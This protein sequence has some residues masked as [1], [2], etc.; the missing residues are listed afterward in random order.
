MAD[1]HPSPSDAALVKRMREGD[2]RA[3]G[4]LYD[5]H[6]GSVY[7]LARSL[8]AEAADADEVVT[9]AFLSLWRGGYDE[10]RGSV[11]AFLNVVAR[12]RALD[13]IRSRRRRG[14]AEERSAEGEP[15]GFAVP[16]SRPGGPEDATE[17]SDRRRVI[18]EALGTLSEKQRS[19]I[20]LAYL[21]GM[22]H[23]EIAAHLSEP[24]GTV[25]TR[26][27]DGMKKL[28][29]RYARTPGEA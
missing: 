6:A 4:L 23:R 18:R 5:R 28:R 8:V 27:R 11:G 13:R 20:S 22:T 24:L 7:S 2:E 9:D 12:S 14:D 19:V 25:K 1:P 21:S 17:R 3:L 15:A 16:V 26:L 29:E 10:S